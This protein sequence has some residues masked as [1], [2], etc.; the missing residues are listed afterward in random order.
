MNFCWTKKI[1]VTFTT[2]NTASDALDLYN[3]NQIV[4][5]GE[6]LQKKKSYYMG[7]LTR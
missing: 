3:F 7:I 4:M 1:L 2:K 6:T 5:G